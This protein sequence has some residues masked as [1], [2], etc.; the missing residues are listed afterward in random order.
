MTSVDDN[1]G[2]KVRRN[3]LGGHDGC[4]N[5]E[6]IRLLASFASDD[7]EAG[8][9]LTCVAGL[10]SRARNSPRGSRLHCFV[11]IIHDIT[12]KRLERLSCLFFNATSCAVV[13]THSSSADD[14]WS[15]PGIQPEFPF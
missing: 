4:I 10:R 13:P 11:R 14:Y 8:D 6:S 15:K 1:H 2:H 3:P 5:T 9:G 12:A 7:D